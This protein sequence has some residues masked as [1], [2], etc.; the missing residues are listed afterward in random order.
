[1]STIAIN[2]LPHRA[3]RR[4][5]RRKSFIS[6]LVLV[7]ILGAVTVLGVGLIYKGIIELQNGRN[8]FIRAENRRLDEQIKE[9]ANLRKEIEALRARQQAVEGLQSDRNQPVHLLDEL[10]KQTPEGV[11]LRSITQEGQKVLLAGVAQSNERVSELLRNLS[12]NSAWL[13]KPNLIEIK[14]GPQA[15]RGVRAY[16]FS[17]DVLIK[18]PEQA[19]AA[20]APA[21]A[22]TPNKK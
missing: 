5:Q 20:G 16:E 11:Y 15:A 22:A 13:E 1:M 3:L 10:V 19:V 9:V 7:L 2:L 21:K 14:A 17:L 12:Y 6:L 4:E 18:R 8:E